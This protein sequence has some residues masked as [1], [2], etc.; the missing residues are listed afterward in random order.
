MAEDKLESFDLDAELRLTGVRP[1]TLL[2]WGKSAQEII[3]RKLVEVFP[4][5]AGNEVHKTLA[6]ALTTGEIQRMRAHSMSMG[7]P[8]AVE[9]RPGPQGLHV[10]F[11]AIGD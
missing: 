1:S 6:R 4:F 5:V 9:I 8:V 10:S 2:I 7:K 11:S 3:G